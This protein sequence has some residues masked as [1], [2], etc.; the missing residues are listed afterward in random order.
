MR[1]ARAARICAYELC[2]SATSGRVARAHLRS[3]IDLRAS[4]IALGTSARG[5]TP[6]ITV[7]VSP[8]LARE[9]DGLRVVA[10]SDVHVVAL[11]LQ[12]PRDGQEEQRMRGVG[13]VDP[14]LHAG[15]SIRMRS[16]SRLAHQ[17][18]PSAGGG[19]GDRRACR[20]ASRRASG[21]VAATSPAISRGSAYQPPGSSCSPSITAP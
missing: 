1:S 2:E 5:L 13:E 20:R 17:I 16:P 3:A 11:P 14:D 19:P 21:A 6:P 7:E 9:L 10:C 8:A 4:A 18:V 15:G 12:L